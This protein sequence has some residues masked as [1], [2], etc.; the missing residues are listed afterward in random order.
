M[1]YDKCLDN[2]KWP[3][4]IMSDLGGD[5]GRAGSLEADP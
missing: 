2:T 1:G 5:S 4:A 3:C